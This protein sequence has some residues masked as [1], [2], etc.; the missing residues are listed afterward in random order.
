MVRMSSLLFL[1]SLTLSSPSHL[2]AGFCL[3]FDVSHFFSFSRRRKKNRVTRQVIK[4]NDLFEPTAITTRARTHAFWTGI[5]LARCYLSLYCSNVGLTYM[6]LI[7][8]LLL[9][10]SCGSQQHYSLGSGTFVAIRTHKINLDN[11]YEMN[12]QKRNLHF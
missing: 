6:A 12:T 8:L 2:S 7:L 3:G 10:S 1:L 9:Q 11:I 4:T 5:W